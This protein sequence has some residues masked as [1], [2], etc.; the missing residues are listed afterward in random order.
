MVGGGYT[1]SGDA[2]LGNLNNAGSTPTDGTALADDLLAKCQMLL[3]EL[4]AFSTFVAEQ[5]LEQD[6]AA[7]TRKFR[8][9]VAT[10]LNLLQ[11]VQ[12]PT[13]SSMLLEE[14]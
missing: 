2:A 3:D 10:E 5:K 1:G 7:E 11:K 8:N 12:W 6:S 4:E 13:A 14:C 9:S